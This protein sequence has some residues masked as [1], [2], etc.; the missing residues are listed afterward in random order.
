MLDLPGNG[1]IQALQAVLEGGR[2]AGPGIVVEGLILNICILNSI[3][4]VSINL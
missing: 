1:V 2:H 4:T 3:S